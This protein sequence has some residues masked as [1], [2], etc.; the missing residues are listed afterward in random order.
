MT[1]RAS[2]RSV[3]L[4]TGGIK[5]INDW[6]VIRYSS[7]QLKDGSRPEEPYWWILPNGDLVALFRDN[8]GS[9]RL[10]R[11]FST[12]NGR[13][14]TRPVRTN[15]PDAMSKF[16]ALRTSRGYYVLV[17]NPNPLGRRPLCLSVS[18][19]GLLFTHMARLPIP[20]QPGE[21]VQYPHVIEREGHLL[22]AFSRNKTAIEVVKI[23]LLE[24]DRLQTDESPA[25]GGG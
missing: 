10:L 3:S 17:S 11:A 9:K 6:R 13:T 24:V 25:D 5:A 7:F 4:L 14:W 21:T 2:D 8:G 1:R 22:I 18:E 19:D 16:N 15:F 23:P 12:D 20:S